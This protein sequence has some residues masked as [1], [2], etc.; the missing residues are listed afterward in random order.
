MTRREVP[1]TIIGATRWYLLHSGR[2]LA[3]T[4]Q[5]TGI[6]HTVL[7]RFSRGERGM[8]MD[9]ID[10]LGEYLGLRVVSGDR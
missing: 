3:E 8:G 9:A 7:S 5:A 6:D 1:N 2:T 10:A 4:S